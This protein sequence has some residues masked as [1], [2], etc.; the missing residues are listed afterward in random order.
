MQSHIFFRPQS[1][2]HETPARIQPTAPRIPGLLAI[3][4]DGAHSAGEVLA[5]FDQKQH[6]TVLRGLAWL[7][8]RDLVHFA[9][10]VPIFC[11]IRRSKQWSTALCVHVGPR[12]MN[13]MC[14]GCELTRFSDT[15]RDWTALV[16]GTG[17]PSRHDKSGRGRRAEVF[18]AT[19]KVA[20]RPL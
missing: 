6:M 16:F 12:T 3:L 4:R 17:V 13:L 7:C 18:C 14:A 9:W 19:K 20:R 2:R 11:V 8:K 5:R 10:W 1:V 15:L